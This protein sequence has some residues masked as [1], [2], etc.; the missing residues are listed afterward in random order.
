MFAFSNGDNLHH[1]IEERRTV[2]REA[3]KLKLQEQTIQ[4]TNPGN[5][6][7]G[8]VA[9]SPTL[10]PAPP[11]PLDAPS[12]PFPQRR[13]AQTSWLSQYLQEDS[14]MGWSKVITAVRTSAPPVGSGA[15][16]SDGGKG[17]EQ[18]QSD[19]QNTAKHPELP[20]QEEF[21]WEHFEQHVAL[22]QMQMQTRPQQQQPPQQPP[23]QPQRPPRA[24]HVR[25]HEEDDGGGGS[26]PPWE[27]G[28]HDHS[29]SFVDLTPGGAEQVV[30][31]G[32]P[33]HSLKAPHSLKRLG[34]TI[35]E[36]SP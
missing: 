14:Q 31:F 20:E 9:E 16:G 26:R 8:H 27:G 36:L 11:P 32:L 21:P 6:Q 18:Q 7:R 24:S 25:S 13:G 19:S 33:I 34:S 5:L 1:Y 23:Q 15:G 17:A 22:P 29:R 3:N 30:E 10:L 4:T 2:L 12:F 35:V 28:P